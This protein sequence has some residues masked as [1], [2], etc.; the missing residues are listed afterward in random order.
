M[1]HR[2]TRPDASRSRAG[3]LAR[4]G[5]AILSAA[6][7]VSGLAA[8]VTTPA[9]AALPAGCTQENL[10]AAVVCTFASTGAEQTFTVPA[11]V[12][13]VTITAIG[14]PGGKGNPETASTGG[15]GAKVSTAIAV[16]PGQ[17]LYVEVGGPGGLGGGGFNGGGGSFF[18]GGGGG[19]S[20]VRTQPRSVPLTTTDSRILVAGGGGGN[21]SGAGQ[22][23]NPGTNGGDAGSPGDAGHNERCTSTGPTG[24]QPGTETAGGA[25]GTP[26][27]G[28]SGGLGVG[29]SLGNG[30][31]P[32]A[33]GGGYFGGGAGG[34]NGVIGGI[35]YG[36]GG[37]G[38]GS[39]YRPLVG[40][41][42]TITS[43][44]PSVTF[45]YTVAPP[46][47]V[48]T[49]TTIDS[50]TDGGSLGVPGYVD[51]S[52]ASSIPNVGVDPT[53]DV[54]VTSDD[55]ATCTAAVATGGCTITFAKTGTRSVVA[56]YAGDTVYAG[57]TSASYPHSVA[58]TA[59]TITVTSTPP[60]P[61]V[62]GGTYS[63]KATSPTSSVTRP[64]TVTVDAAAAEVCTI[65][66][67]TVVHLVHAG[68]C[69]LDFD[70]VGDDTYAPAQQV[71][72][73]FQ[74]APIPVTVTLTSSGNPVAYGDAATVTA[75]ATA[76]DG[77]HP[78]G[79]IFF[80]LRGFG[81]GDGVTVAADGTATK[82]LGAGA[83]PGTYP[84]GASFVPTDD[85]TYDGGAAAGLTQLVNQ[86]ATSTVLQVTS[87]ALTA[88]VTRN[89]ALVDT[90]DVDAPSGT[91]TFTV[92]GKTVGTA[93]L[94]DGSA[95]LPVTNA[96]R[97][98]VGATYSGDDNYMMST[99][100]TA[101]SKPTI[102]ATVTSRYGKSRFG[103]YRSPVTVSFRCSATGAPL[104]GSCPSP[105]TLRRDGAA[106]VV[107]RS[108]TATDGG[109][110]S[111]TVRVNL[112]QRRPSVRVA[113]V[114]NGNSYVATPTLRCAASD[115]LS[116]V[117]SCRL[118][119]STRGL[120]TTYTAV[121]TDRAGNSST[122]RGRYTVRRI[123]LLG[124]PY[125]RGAYTVHTGRTYTMVVYSTSRPRYYDAA[126]YPKR[127]SPR[128]NKFHAAGRHRWTLAVTMQRSL[129]THPLWNIGAKI[130][131][132]LYS[133][134]IRIA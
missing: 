16:T 65:D 93:T 127:P 119:R 14:A 31:L 103:W 37:G 51:F 6:V 58:G 9:S 20:D 4:R 78:A 36:G 116:G 29:Q 32:G 80:S 112:D 134:K 113:G 27:S 90:E 13:A 98:A 38:G 47:D 30:A 24:G 74:V 23:C 124:A 35:D 33:G 70:Q 117:A 92:A 19:A 60:S 7:T 26:S 115:A 125:T 75:T 3:T 5:L 96:A 69:T 82:V 43:D 52:V 104:A 8:A 2:F 46:T 114:R 55:G 83:N 110:A 118:T 108:V 88:T 128:D 44:P 11:D 133:I 12:S 97:N 76:A 120:T 63:P 34:A 18:G 105:V 54:T 1:T 56:T 95:T 50:I 64:V 106:Q 121:A 48:P 25:R 100:S 53:G 71:Q 10:F 39:S 45:S 101:P 111:V 66:S 84:L 67:A 61:A 40:T 94:V 72:Q 21:G 130:G 85:T 68:T 28:G 109:T 17:T 126:V 79:S 91:V 22:F 57:S 107:S 59:Q 73:Q 49:T 86:A 132:K 102:T 77:T 62:V 42:P 99:A 122:T 15:R 89:P 81:F 129:R 131:K 41:G 87:T 123:A